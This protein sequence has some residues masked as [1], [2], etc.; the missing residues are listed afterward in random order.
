MTRIEDIRDLPEID[1]TST[2]MF[3]RQSLPEEYWRPLVEKSLQ[4]KAV[5]A[6]DDILLIGGLYQSS[7]VSYPHLWALVSPKMR[8]I[9]VSDYR[10]I[11]RYCDGLFPGTE[12][13]INKLDSGAD[14]LARFF[15]YSATGTE[16]LFEETPYEIY[17]RPL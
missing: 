1:L 9:S 4:M 10:A 15:G 17:R 16:F 3:E 12:T 8:D 14:R 7:F 11:R 5:Y 13:Y 2:S 6:G